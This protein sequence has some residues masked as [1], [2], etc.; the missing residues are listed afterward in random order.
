MILNNYIIANLQCRITVCYG[1]K[2]LFKVFNRFY[3]MILDYRI[4]LKYIGK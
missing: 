2:N 1:L 3:F 4:L